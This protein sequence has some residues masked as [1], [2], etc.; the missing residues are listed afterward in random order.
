[1]E[2]DFFR[3]AESGVVEMA[4]QGQYTTTPLQL[5]TAKQRSPE[6][7]HAWAE[8]SR[9]KR[10][11]KHPTGA[12]A[13]AH[14][15]HNLRR[16]KARQEELKKLQTTFKVRKKGHTAQQ[17][18]V[19]NEQQTEQSKQ[20]L[21][22]YCRDRLTDQNRDDQEQQGGMQTIEERA[23]RDPMQEK[24]RLGGNE[25]SQGARRRSSDG[26]NVAKPPNTAET[27]SR[28]LTMPRHVNQSDTWREV[29]MVAIP[30]QAGANDFDEHRYLSLMA[31]MSKWMVRTLVENKESE[32]NPGR[33]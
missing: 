3:K 16:G 19:E 33:G 4:M 12:Q 6:E 32:N 17:L 28:Y 24:L 8:A 13:C 20:G 9:A 14:N 15:L 27:E 5:W 7:K 18:K 22:S 2:S 1:M 25:N 21:F 29:L 26:G 11:G 31:T 23:A 10:A 30:I